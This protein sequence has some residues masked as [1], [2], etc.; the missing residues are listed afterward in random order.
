MGGGRGRGKGEYQWYLE[1]RGFIGHWCEL[2]GRPAT[3][4]VALIKL[5]AYKTSAN[6][7]HCYLAYAHELETVIREGFVRV[8]D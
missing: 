8:Q 3:K 4:K 1:V 7:R 6:E 2:W 5:A